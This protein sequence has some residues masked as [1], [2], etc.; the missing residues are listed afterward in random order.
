MK[1]GGVGYV[2]PGQGSFP[3]MADMNQFVL[4]A[5]AIPTL[6]WL[7]GTS[8]G[9]QS[10]EELF[11]VAQASGAAALNIIPDRNYTPG[12]VD[13]KLKNLQQVIELAEQRHFPVIVGTEMNSPGNKFVD[14]FETAELKPFLPIFWKGAHIVYAHS[15]LQRA[16]G[17]GYLS[18]WATT[19]FSTLAE[20]NNFFETVGQRLQPSREDQ[21]QNLTTETT[22]SMIINQLD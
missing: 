14:S 20:K 12:L 1:R 4:D 13:Q 2:Q 7:D 19:Q 15:I 3:L 5:N 17:L 8:D 18:Q 11:D 22:P 16:S 9:E 6:T 21:L 10:I